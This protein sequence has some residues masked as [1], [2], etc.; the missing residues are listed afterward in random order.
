MKSYWKDDRLAIDRLKR[1]YE[2]HKNLIIGYDFDSTIY[3]YHKQGID[4]EPVITL[5][6]QCTTL[7]FTMCL[8]TVPTESLEGMTTIDKMAYCEDLG[9]GVHFFNTGPLFK[10]S[11]RKAFFS[12]LLDDRAGL[13]SAYN[14]LR[15]ALLELN[16]IL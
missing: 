11:K 15:T 3:D 14:T 13:A 12:I 10:N 8:W 5:L 9:I 1:E 4:F 16:L 6:R 2:Q 7:G